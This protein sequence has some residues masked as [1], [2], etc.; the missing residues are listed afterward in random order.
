M[1]QNHIIKINSSN[2]IMGKNLHPINSVPTNLRNWGRTN[3]SNIFF[4]IVQIVH[5]CSWPLFETHCGHHGQIRNFN[6]YARFETRPKPTQTYA[7]THWRGTVSCFW[8][9][10]WQ[11]V[12]VTNLSLVLLILSV[13]LKYRKYQKKHKYP[14][15]ILK[16]FW[17]KFP[18]FFSKF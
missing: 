4:T 6:F 1:A 15:E 17:K 8:D 10:F 3:I 7:L 9:F 5:F 12:F 18:F 14:V 13:I 11:K 16:I 2:G